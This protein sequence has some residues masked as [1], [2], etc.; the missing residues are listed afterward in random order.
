[1]N[2]SNF[3]LEV[4]RAQHAQRTNPEKDTSD[5]KICILYDQALKVPSKTNKQTNNTV[6]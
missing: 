2:N 3:Q 5:C 1:M 4:F 6:I